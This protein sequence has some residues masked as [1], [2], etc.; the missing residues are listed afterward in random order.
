MQERPVS[1]LAEIFAAEALVDEPGGRYNIAPTD[2]A[3]VVV[4]R[5]DRRALD[6]LPLGAD[7][8]LGTG[9]AHR[10]ANVQRPGRIDRVDA[11]VP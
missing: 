6:G 7:P 2:E 8:A 4:E 10:V 3:I 9:C 1:D 11:G 5:D